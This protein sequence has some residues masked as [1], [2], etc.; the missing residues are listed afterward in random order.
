MEMPERWKDDFGHGTHV[1]EI[2]AA[3]T[4]KRVGGSGLAYPV[5]VIEYKVLNLR[6]RGT[7]PTS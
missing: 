1:T 3:A 6:D 2:L 4:S 7:M 5:Q